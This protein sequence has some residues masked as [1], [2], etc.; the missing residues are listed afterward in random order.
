[1]SGHSK[2]STIK[3]KKG[4]NDAKKGK[5]FTKLVR[6]VT[7]AARLG[8]G[9]LQSNPRLRA[10]IAAAKASRMPADNIERA[11]KKGTG[12]LEGP[13]VEEVAY[14]GY[15]A[16]GVAFY[17]EAQTDNRH[18]TSSDVRAAFSKQGG[19]LGA[20][21]SVSYLFTKRGVVCFAQSDCS[22]AQLLDALLDAG[23]DELRCEEG[24]WVLECAPQ[25][26]PAVID[27]ADAAQLRYDSAAISML[28]ETT[29]PVGGEEAEQVMRLFERLDDLDDVQN[30]HSNFTLTAAEA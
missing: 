22:E 26:L 19:N 10:A 30:V 7:T 3:R 9:E 29:I 15:G 27:A 17:V 6:E 24:Q 25:D 5:I 28:P 21:G 1:M 12:V 11:I 4:A 18:R 13:P 16:G 2:W 20:T 23:A 14:E 8:G